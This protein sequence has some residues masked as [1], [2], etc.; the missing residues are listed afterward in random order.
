MRVVIFE[1]NKS[2]ANL[3]SKQLFLFPSW[4]VLQN[5]DVWFDT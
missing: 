5:F 1:Y 3:Y 4:L 2:S